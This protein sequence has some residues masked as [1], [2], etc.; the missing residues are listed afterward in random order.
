MVIYLRLFTQNH[1]KLLNSN[2]AHTAT[3]HAHVI[4]A[5]VRCISS[6]RQIF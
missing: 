1:F 2:F 4:A 6:V 5:R 3:E